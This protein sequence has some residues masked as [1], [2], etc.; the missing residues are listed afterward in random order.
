MN[1]RAEPGT[2]PI[3]KAVNALDTT[4]NLDDLGLQSNTQYEIHLRVEFT[5]LTKRLKSAV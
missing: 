3:R 1:C 5:I 2:M 4:Y